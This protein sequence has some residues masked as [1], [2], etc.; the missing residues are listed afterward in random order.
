VADTVCGRL[1]S[2]VAEPC[3]IQEVSA[4]LAWAGQHQIAVAPRGG[5]SKLEWG[6]PPRKIDLVISTAALAVVAEHAHEDMTATVDA[7]CTVS[8]LQR[9][10]GT[11]G[12]RLAL[13]PLF[14]E[15]ATIGGVLATNDSGALRLRFGSLRD[16]VIGMTVVLP[17]GTVARSGGKVVKNVAGYDLPKL[18]AGSLGTLGIIVQATFR[19]HPVPAACAVFDAR[20]TDLRSA[21]DFLL[22][23]MD[24][25]L[26]PSAVQL[27]AGRH[28][29]V[30]VD[31]L[32]E[33]IPAGVESQMRRTAEFGVMQDGAGVAPGQGR[34]PNR[35]A[36]GVLRSREDFWM[37]TGPACICK[38]S[39]L[40]ARVGATCGHV[41][42]LA[43]ELQLDWLATVQAVGTG[44]VLLQGEAE[45]L[46]SAVTQLRAQIEQGGGSLVILRR[47]E[48]WRQD[49][50]S[51][52]STGSALPLMRALKSQ[53]DPQGVLNPGRFVGGI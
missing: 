35:P 36:F 45:R 41:Q 13:D 8:A 30:R 40:P 29:E 3:T 52:G 6:N 47:P 10:L 2:Y 15:R 25:T 26:T 46:S 49:I 17:D 21:Q 14:P 19:L 39:V 28:R 22:R 34:A 5:G 51:W 18:L 20:F 44:L 27:G 48:G 4:L 42:W 53:F 32:Y 38:L 50:D 12:Q 24:S 7:G 1:P 37:H 23:L 9:A 31:V 43:N 16:L 11:R 33:G